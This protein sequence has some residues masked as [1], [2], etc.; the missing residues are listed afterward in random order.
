MRELRDL[1]LFHA[2]GLWERRW[3]ILAVAW[4]ICLGGWLMVALVAPRYTATATIYVDTESVLGPLMRDLAVTPDIDRQLAVMRQTLLSR[5]NIEELIQDADLDLELGPMPPPAEFAG[6]VEQ[7]QRNIRIDFRGNN[8]F[9][10]GYT[11]PD[12]ERAYRVVDEIL[13]IFVDQNT[14]NTQEDVEGARAFID[15]RLADYEEQLRAAE[16][17]VAKFRRENAAELAGVQR[18]ESELSNAESRL[19]QLRAER[20]AAVWQRDQLELRLSET[21]PSI[22]ATELTAEPTPA[23]QRLRELQQRLD[24]LR[25]VFTDR[26]PDVARLRALIAQAERDVRAEGGSGA[27]GERPNPVHE[28]L[29]RDL[30]SVDAAIAELDRRIGRAEERVEE[31]S[32][33]A[34]ETPE[35]EAE[36]TRLTRDYEILRERYRSLLDRRESAEL[37]QRLETETNRIEFRMV[38]PPM[39]PDKPSGPPYG[40]MMLGVVVAGL[41]ASGGLALMRVVLDPRVVSIDQLRDHFD[42][43]ILGAVSVVRGSLR[44]TREVA[45]YGVFATALVALFAAA[46]TLYVVY[47]QPVPPNVAVIAGAFLESRGV[48][49]GQLL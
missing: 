48:D 37:G 18:I 29:E 49:L 16:L 23:E 36:L 43:P 39:V 26:H 1:V 46:G 3:S 34:S 40:V 28:Q 31:L 4:V 6:L 2:A 32:V 12:A 42:L 35:V 17:A 15:R 33:R 25:L 14:G 45:A 41:G 7:L 10:V 19:D 5:P 30:R 20:E 11:H 13:Q 38:E 9:E 24:E 22:P 8:I 21:P 47:S 27:G 44:R